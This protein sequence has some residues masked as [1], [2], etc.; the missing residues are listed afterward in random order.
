[1]RYLL[2]AIVIAGF[3]WL[4]TRPRGRDEETSTRTASRAEA[5]PR[6][7]RA[8]AVPLWAVAGGSASDTPPVADADD[9]AMPVAPMLDPET[10]T[11]ARDAALP[12]VRACVDGEGDA[13]LA[14]TIRVEVVQGRVR[15]ADARSDTAAVA[16]C[17][18]Q[19]VHALDLAAPTDQ[20]DGVQEVT[21]FAGG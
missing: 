13:R 3:S 21:L 16:A 6:S 1:M 9:A 12:A 11:L 4:V 5:T 20:P 17:V 18:A 19:A 2:L 7:M 15:I 8:V 10:F 14:V